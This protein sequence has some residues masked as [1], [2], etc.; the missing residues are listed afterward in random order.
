[1]LPGPARRGAAQGGMVV[2]AATWV[3]HWALP[4]C[5][6]VVGRLWGNAYVE[7]EEEGRVLMLLPLTHILSS[8]SM[9][10]RHT[11][12]RAHTNT[13]AHTHARTNTCMHTCTHTH[14]HT[15]TRTHTHARTHTHTHTCRWPAFSAAWAARSTSLRRRLRRRRAGSRAPPPLRGAARALGTALR[16]ALTSLASRCARAWRCVAGN[17][18]GWGGGEGGGA[19]WRKALASL[20]SRCA[21]A[22]RC[23]FVVCGLCTGCTAC[24]CGVRPLIL[25]WLGHC[26][27]KP[28]ALTLTL[29]FTPTP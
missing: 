19:A 20:A 10:N 29:T 9:L 26:M 6:L 16:R 8:A 25:M 18:W 4:P 21:R 5:V 11:Q 1:V 24:R 27:C 17:G 12:M 13:L 2:G 22:W 14:K 15:H 28:G 23:M 3:P 7:R